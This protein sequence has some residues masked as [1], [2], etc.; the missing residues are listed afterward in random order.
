MWEDVRV[1]VRLLF[2]QIGIQK[3]EK[4]ILSRFDFKSIFLLQSWQWKIYGERE[5]EREADSERETERGQFDQ[6]PQGS[7]SPT[8]G[9]ILIWSR[10][11]S[12]LL[13]LDLP[14]PAQDRPNQTRSNRLETIRQNNK[15]DIDFNESVTE[16][17]MLQF[18][19]NEKQAPNVD[20]SNSCFS[21]ACE[22]RRKALIIW[23]RLT[24]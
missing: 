21:F 18:L 7:L 5:G 12:L 8:F 4:P 16:I 23:R 22:T 20:I 14:S 10:C 15:L 6:I 24:Q 1:P 13:I 11:F 19:A 3:S 9:V 2:W 17:T